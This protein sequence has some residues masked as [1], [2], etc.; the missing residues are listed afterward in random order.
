MNKQWFTASLGGFLSVS[1]SVFGNS[2][3]AE[4]LADI[5]KIEIRGELLPTTTDTSSN[6]VEVVNAKAIEQL[7]AA[8][9]QDVLQ[10][11]G[12]VNYASGSSRARFFQIRGMGE[13]SQFVDPVNPSV[14]L[15]IDG[16]DYTGMANAAT[17]F[18]VSQVEVFK[19]PQGTSVGANAMAGFI[20]LFGAEP[21]A[22]TES[23][24]RLEVGN[25]GLTNLAAATGG[26]VGEHSGYRFS[27]N[28]LD[29]D[30]YI[31][32][33]HLNRD[34][35]NVFDELT[36]RFVA[37]TQLN[38]DWSVKTVVHK[39]DIDNGYDAFSLDQNRET[40]SDQP[41]FDQQDTQSLGFTVEHTGLASFDHKFFVSATDT[42]LAY[43]YDEDWAFV[44]IHPDEYTSTDHY[45][46][47]RDAYQFDYAASSK[48]DDWV[49]GLYRRDTETDLTRDYTYLPEFMSNYQVASVALYG[50]KR[51]VTSGE[52][53]ITAGL[54]VE[55][56]DSE[57]ADSNGTQV[58]T[59]DTMWGGHISAINQYTDY[60][61][62][63]VRV[64]RGFKAGGVNG[65]SLGRIGEEGLEQFEF[66]L[67]DRKSFEPEIL[68]NIEMGVRTSNR[69]HS[70]TAR[71]NLFYSSRDN[72]QVK[73]WIHNELAV[74]QD[75]APPKFVGYIS[76]APEGT[77]YG[78]ETSLM[79]KP[80]S[81]LRLS[82]GFSLL[83]SEV[84]NM[85]RLVTDPV[86]YEK[87]RVS[88]S[89]RDQAHAPRYQYFLAGEW[90]WTDRISTSLSVTGKDEYYYS[91]SHDSKSSSVNLVNASLTYRGDNLDI[92]LWSRNVTDEEYGV[93]GFNFGNDPRD[94][95]TAKTYEQLGEPRVYGVKL[96]FVF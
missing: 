3:A 80:T 61:S 81:S 72:M 79:Y 62:V 20:N 39:F 67:L 53:A 88:I 5:E 83:E 31:Q 21:G 12:N 84:K 89:G 26:D 37:N 78:L 68:E 43:G 32:N 10:Q 93:R 55:N 2:V 18:D 30:G 13:R 11:L 41:G 63:Y 40:L 48:D 38:Q 22:G 54:R 17:L 77:N 9:L 1:P 36:M 85:Y 70:L 69:D 23:K 46:R 34:D 44:G 82:A 95:Y 64:S 42:E 50:E 8:H 90:Q 92:T 24:L 71:A 60:L 91:F 25:Y 87:S 14:G 58:D 86:T 4:S 66:E 35:T 94:G 29:G 15:A 65:E 33:V 96:D 49:V 52:L 57:Y 28:K 51:L 47:D 74:Q 56:Y 6:A 75:D 27:I 7:G 16:I 45:F 59:S 76:N 73:Q 19:G